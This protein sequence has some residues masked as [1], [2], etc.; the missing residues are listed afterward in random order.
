MTESPKL[1]SILGS[2]VDERAVAQIET[3]LSDPEAAFGALSADHHVGYS[4]PIG[5]IVAY[6]NAI[7]PSGVGYDIACGNKAVLTDL[8]AAAIRPYMA[9]IMD[10]VF[11]QIEFGMGRAN[12]EAV[13][14]DLFGDPAWDGVP[15]LKNLQQLAQQ[16]LGTVGSGNH[17]VDIFADEADRVWVG[18]HFGSRGFGH[19]TC[20]GFMNLAHGR[21][22]FDKPGGEDMDARATVFGLDTAIGQDYFAAMKLAGRYAYA[23]R[24]Y[25]CARVLKIL[26]AGAVEEVH[27]HHNFAW[28]EEHFGERLVVVRKGATPAF[29]GQR[30]FIGGSMGEDAVIAEGVES[31]AARNLLQSTVHGAGRVMSRTAARGKAR[32]VRR[33]QCQNY[34]R[35]DYSG[36]KGGFHKDPDG[37]TPRC[38][39][40]GH[41]LR[42]TEMREQLKPGLISP[43]M[44]HEWLA[45][46]GIVLRGGGTDEAPQA[47]KRLPEVLAH[48][49][50]AI[51]ILHTLSPMGVAMAG[52]D[53]FDPYKD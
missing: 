10:E 39:E 5:G 33:W 15:H 35:C 19:K 3:C 21:G 51:R 14:H 20:T 52:E 46:R 27:N 41:K 36:A 25:V 44:M 11:R 47:Y 12:S 37:P 22:F 32:R 42:L 29:P 24:D 31:E 50:G 48:H 8:K 43:E 9:E 13:E 28:E 26:G 1:L 53:V 23:G 40:C 2:P 34:R 4:M 18:V 30:C 17:Y 38:P 16:Q 7:S 45:E 6:R 49:D